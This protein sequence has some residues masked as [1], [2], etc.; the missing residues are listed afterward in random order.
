MEN[1]DQQV[2]NKLIIFLVL[3]I[4]PMIVGGWVSHHKKDYIARGVV[5]SLFS[6]WFGPIFMYFQ[7]ESK[8]R[9]G[10]DEDDKSWPSNGPAACM[11][12]IGAIILYYI[13]RSLF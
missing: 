11:C 9:Q 13:V 5:I 8:A 6:S 12:F 3:S 4:L 2:I 10:D 1:I 7:P